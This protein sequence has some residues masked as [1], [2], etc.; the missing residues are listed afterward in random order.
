MVTDRE[1]K[2][3]H[4]KVTNLLQKGS[5]TSKVGNKTKNLTNAFYFNSDTTFAKLDTSNGE[6]SLY[7]ISDWG[8]AKPKKDPDDP[9]EKTKYYEKAYSSSS[10]ISFTKTS[11]STTRR[12]SVSVTITSRFS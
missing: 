1:R 6:F 12:S 10:G 7:T 5:F 4:G 3:N 11:I 9:N 8:A 2:I